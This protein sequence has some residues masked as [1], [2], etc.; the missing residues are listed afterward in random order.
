MNE[1]CL[2]A[3]RVEYADS[4]VRNEL[5]L[6]LAGG[7][8][9]AGYPLFDVRGAKPA[10]RI[11]PGMVP[12]VAEA[13]IAYNER[14]GNQPDK[15]LKQAVCDGA[16]MVITGQQ[17]GLLTGPLYTIWKAL[18][19]IRLAEELSKRWG[20][21]VVP[22]FWIATEDHD[23]L[24]VNRVRIGDKWF[25]ADHVEAK[26]SGPGPRGRG[27]PPVG[28]VSLT[29]QRERMLTFLREHLRGDF[30]GEVTDAIASA[31][32]RDYGS[33]FA[34]LLVK[35]L[36]AGRVVLVDPMVL[37]E[38]A[39]P[40][41][42]R[43]VERWDAIETGFARGNERLMKEGFKPQLEKV[44]MFELAEGRRLSVDVKALRQAQMASGGWFSAGA[45]L[46]PVLQDALLPTVCTIG[47]PAEM[48]YLWQIDGVYEAME[49]ERSKLWPRSSVTLV[50][51]ATR[52]LA[53]RFGLHGTEILKAL[54]QAETYDARAMDAVDE[55]MRK[56]RDRL[57]AMLE[58]MGG[59]KQT[60]RR[61]EKAR[62]SLRYQIDKVLIGAGRDKMAEQGMDRGALMQVMRAICP[63][64]PQERVNNVWDFAARYGWKWIKE[65]ELSL[66]V[67]KIVHT[68]MDLE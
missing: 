17:P 23:L 9:P 52:K 60:R 45:G 13:L 2:K 62:R 4:P 6:R 35:V 65:A 38:A 29:G 24:E 37:R 16:P 43:A 26:M 50:D 54:K 18:S 27:R 12:G 21:T 8:A 57:L 67:T 19:V 10:T 42:R 20:V 36:G 47:G 14:V 11:A 59:S 44:G 15:A 66:D 56:Q 3:T 33:L 63:D 28:W 31:D 64:G 30:S 58:A 5:L 41:M 53:E 40:V 34:S 55:G 51:A 46:R 68:M 22:A 48:L 25:V 61:V 49:V 7:N 32:W 39:E 1:G